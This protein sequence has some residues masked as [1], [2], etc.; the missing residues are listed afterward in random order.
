MQLWLGCQSNSRYIQ[1]TVTAAAPSD[2]DWISVLHPIAV[3]CSC[4]KHQQQHQQ[5]KCD[6]LLTLL[7]EKGRA[8]GL[9]EMALLLQKLSAIVRVRCA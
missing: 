6:W 8:V 7:V 2:D 5:A 3:H 9:A 4:P 1:S